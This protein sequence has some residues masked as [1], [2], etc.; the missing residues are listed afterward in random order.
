MGVENPNF[1]NSD[2]S[3]FGNIQAIEIDRMKNNGYKTNKTGFEVGTNFEYY[4]DFKLG[5]S[6]GAFYEKIDI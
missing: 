5:F 6:T 3:L 2:K 4:E 1:N